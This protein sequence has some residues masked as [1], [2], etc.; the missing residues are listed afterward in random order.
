ME[1]F[2]KINY[3]SEEELNNYK[4]ELYQS[5]LDDRE[6][7]TKIT[8]EGF[9]KEE[10]YANLTKFD[11]Y[12]KNY[13][14]VK[15]IENY[16]DCKKYNCYEAISLYKDGRFIER[17]VEVL[18]PVKENMLYFTRFLYKDFDKKF[19]DIRYKDIDNKSLRKELN[20][21]IKNGKWL[22]LYGGHRSGKTFASIATCNEFIKAKEGMVAFIDTTKTF[23]DILKDYFNDK[24]TFNKNLKK[25]IN[26]EVLV[27]DNFG[28][29]YKNDMIRD[30]LLI[31]LLQGRMENKKLTIFTS[32]YTISEVTTLYSNGKKV[33][34]LMSRQ[35][36]DIIE[37]SIDGPI[38]FT[39][40]DGLY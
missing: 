5:I 18:A 30:A 7:F 14:I 35:I 2:N 11:E 38:E 13:N 17:Q 37:S 29:E 8:N 32:N 33:G 15:N 24:E 1:E 28:A 10:I 20:E 6:F 25:L 34:E 12:R 39:S 31:P 9:S 40:Q 19:N 16:E 21:N 3:V 23:N 27:L 22:Y 4:K 36:K 26:C